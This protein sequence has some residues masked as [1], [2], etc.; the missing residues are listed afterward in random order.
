MGI[1]LAKRDI[2]TSCKSKPLYWKIYRVHQTDLIYLDIWR[3]VF[4]QSL[5]VLNALFYSGY[6]CYLQNN[7]S[8]LR[9]KVFL[10]YFNGVSAIH[11]E[12]F[13][14]FT[15]LRHSTYRLLSYFI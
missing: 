11:M 6:A 5:N 1:R 14:D 10:Q 4:Q 3:R 13:Y 7:L 12:Q 2:Y 15:R 9:W 8:R